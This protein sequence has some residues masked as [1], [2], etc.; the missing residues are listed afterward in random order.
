M[1]NLKNLKWLFFCLLFTVLLLPLSA[2]FIYGGNQKNKQSRPKDAVADM[3]IKLYLH[4]SDKVETVNAYDYIRGV[5]FAEMPADFEPEALKAQSVA[6]FTYTVNKMEYVINNPDSDVGHKGG[7]VCDNSNHCKAYI[8]IEEVKKRFSDSDIDKISSAVSETLGEVI[9]YDGKPITAVFHSISA[10]KTA[11]ALEVWGSEL[12]YLKSVPCQDDEKCPDFKSTVAFTKKE[13][14]DI[15][16]DSLSVT[17]PADINSWIGEIKYFDSGYI[18]TVSIGGT[19]YSGS[20]LRQLFSLR[21]SSFKI[22]IKDQTVVFTV[23]GYGHGAGMSQNGANEMAKKGNSY[24]QI[25]KY[26]Y[27]DTSIQDYNIAV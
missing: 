22:K 9:T 15:M 27:T 4:K 1:Q 19:A 23:S 25:L 3:E 8:P 10:G 21:S 6:A 17:L 14:A 2:R 18:N 12:P 20:Y 24:K 13:F 7:Y 5:L 11:S 26:F 16:Q